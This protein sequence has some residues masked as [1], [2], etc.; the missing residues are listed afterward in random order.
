M[1]RWNGV[2]EIRSQG[3]GDRFHAISSIVLL[4]G[5]LRFPARASGSESSLPLSTH[6]SGPV[7]PFVQ[8]TR[9]PTITVDGALRKF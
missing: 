8:V 2:G 9:S 3:H 7:Y 1:D 4:F 6:P 5:A